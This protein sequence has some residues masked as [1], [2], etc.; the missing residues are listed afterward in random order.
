MIWEAQFGDF[1]NGAQVIIDAFISSGEGKSVQVIP[2]VLLL[3][4]N[5]L[6]ASMVVVLC[7]SQVAAAEWASDAAAP[8]I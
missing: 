4:M 6:L 3:V 1:F 2:S 7:D 5:A 8:W